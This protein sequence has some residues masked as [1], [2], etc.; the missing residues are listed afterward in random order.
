[1]TDLL[2]AAAHC[3]SMTGKG[4]PAYYFFTTGQVPGWLGTNGEKWNHQINQESRWRRRRHLR[5][6]MLGRQNIKFFI[7]AST[8]WQLLQRFKEG[9]IIII[10]HKQGT[11]YVPGA[12]RKVGWNYYC[13]KR[14]TMSP[15]Y[16]WRNLHQT[17][18]MVTI[19]E[20]K[21]QIERDK[22][23]RKCRLS[24]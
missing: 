8:R 13:Y 17:A 11:L 12:G 21:L 20:T 7:T 19:I 6:E 23:L 24:I 14:N 5:N 4:Y 9:C 3:H 1:M 18:A 15:Y 2:H 22:F 10:M 16:L